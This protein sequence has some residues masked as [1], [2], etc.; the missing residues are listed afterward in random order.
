MDG[1]VRVQR[2]D[3]NLDL[4]VDSGFLF[5]VSAD[6][7]EC[8]NSLSV[9][10][11]VLGKALTEGNLVPLLDKVPHGMR[12]SVGVSAGKALVGHVKERKVIL[13]LDNVGDLLPI[14]SGRVDTSRVVSAG[15]EKNNRLI[16]SRSEVCQHP[17]QVEPDSFLV[18]VLVILDLEPA[19]LEDGNVVTPCRRWQVDGLGMGVVTL[20]E[21]SSNSQCTGSRNRLSDRH[22][23]LFDHWTVFAVSKDSSI[24]GKIG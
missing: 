8:T 4:A 1:W 23:S 17:V 14:V 6:K 10:A 24:L 18:I 7:R 13:F 19:I 20:Q 16:G 2:P 22:S 15:V 9:Q 11:H 5:L 3:N 21:G 12:I